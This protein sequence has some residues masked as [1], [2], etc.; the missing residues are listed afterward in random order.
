MSVSSSRLSLVPQVGDARLFNIGMGSLPPELLQNYTK[1][2]GQT[3]A[4]SIQRSR[5]GVLTGLFQNGYLGAKHLWSAVTNAREL[6][7]YVLYSRQLKKDFEQKKAPYESQRYIYNANGRDHLPSPK[8]LSRQEGGQESSIKEVNQAYE[9]SGYTFGFFKKH[10]G[11]VLPQP[12]IQVVN[13]NN[14]PL[15]VGFGNA[16]FAPLKMGLQ[17]MV[18]GTGDKRYFNNFT[19]D[20]TVIAHELSHSYLDNIFPGK[21][22]YA[23]QPGALNEHIADVIGKCV[24]AQYKGW[25][26]PVG[27][28]KF[29]ADLM[30]NPNFS[31]RDMMNPGQ[32]YDDP[33]LGKDRQVGHMK[34]F[35]VTDDDH[36]G[37]HLNSGIMSRVFALFSE[38]MKSPLYDLPLKVWVRAIKKSAA[39]PSFKVFGKALID[40][41]EHYKVKQAML[42]ALSTTGVLDYEV[43][44]D[45]VKRVTPM[46][47]EGMEISELIIKGIDKRV[48]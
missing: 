35:V 46:P 43:V 10:L 24:E 39:N 34:D 16:Y 9:Y 5:A 18:Y 11:F 26:G 19:N 42:D 22:S 6:F 21:F 12:M 23:G 3:A 45:E 47:N 33:D 36:G 2:S 15:F 25:S 44:G 7:D 14:N 17:M 40:A 4:G 28:W 27:N 30:V 37:V 48:A 41:A 20:I 38:S 8:T 29:G 13:F 31:L 32:A 1:V